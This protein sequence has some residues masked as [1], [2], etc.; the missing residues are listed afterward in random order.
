V[1]TLLLVLI[2]LLMLIGC[3]G[4][5]GGGGGG[6]NTGGGVTRLLVGRV[7]WVPTGAPTNPESTVQVGAATAQTNLDDGSFE[8]SAPETA[9]EIIVVWRAT[10]NSSPVVFTFQVPAGVDTTDL[11]DL[12]I[13]PETTTVTG[14]VLSTADSVPIPDA[15]V[16]FGGRTTKTAADGTWTLANIAYSST[17]LASFLGIQGKVTRA[18]FNATTFF[19]AQGAVGGVVTIPDILMSP[20]SDPNPPPSP[21]NIWGTVSPS[22]FASGTIVQL[23]E[24]GVPIRQFTVGADG[25]YA[26][27]IVAGSYVI[28]ANNPGNGKSAA[29]Q[30]VTLPTSDTVLRKDVALQ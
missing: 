13:G 23:L 25:K 29:D 19:P 5:G 12:W 26:F 24:N 10:P 4:G 16:S 11:G 7:L 22:Q 27:W 21:F 18:G 9:T 1:K 3:G 17:D 8:I 14:R 20:E 28:R 2:A 15:E 30:S 6:T